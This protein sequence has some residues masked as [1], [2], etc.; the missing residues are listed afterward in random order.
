[1]QVCNF[2]TVRTN[3]SRH[4]IKW[5]GGGGERDFTRKADLLPLSPV[6][7]RLLMVVPKSYQREGQPRKTE[8]E[9]TNDRS[10]TV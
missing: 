8:T 10:K 5:G 4:L 7:G 2:T 3:D 9:L 6:Q 1:M